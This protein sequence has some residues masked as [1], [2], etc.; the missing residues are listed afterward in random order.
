MQSVRT[1][2]VLV[3][4]AER[5]LELR[6]LLLGELLRHLPDQSFLSLELYLASWVGGTVLRWWCAALSLSLEAE[7]VGRKG[8]ERIEGRKEREQ[9]RRGGN[10]FLVN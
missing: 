1:V 4:E 9:E 3:E 2:A 10:F 8:K 6:D 5:L 7:G